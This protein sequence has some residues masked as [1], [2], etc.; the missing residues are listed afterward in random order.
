M[1][2]FIRNVDPICIK[3]IDEKAKRLKMSRNEYI[4][5]IV[6]SN[7]DT[8]TIE[9]LQTA[10]NKTMSQLLALIEENINAL[11]KIEMIIGDGSED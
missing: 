3:K 7:A 8:L 10:S 1:D 5:N 4:K 11:H 2:L 6:E 9:S